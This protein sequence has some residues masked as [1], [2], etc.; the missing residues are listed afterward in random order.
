MVVTYCTV[1]DVSDF[2]RVPI[3]ATTTPNKT[4]VEKIINRKEDE[5]E[6]RIGHAWRERTITNEVHDLPLVYSFGWGTPVFLQHRMIKDMDSAQGDK[7]EIW[8]GS[9]D[10]YSDILGNTSWHNIEGV[11][12]K[13]FLRGF[14]FSILR[15]HRV[16]VTYRYGDTVVPGDITDAL[17]KMTAIELLNT[18][19]RM[20][21]L[22]MGGD[23]INMQNSMQKWQ[24]DIDRTIS[25]RR[26]V[27]VVR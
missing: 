21:K 22:P 1:T 13:L 16:R 20:D 7:I 11:Y 25:D 19:F 24:E 10:T 2:L 23:G 12:G 9:Q 15:K 3:T 26:E 4:Q 27:F 18:S 5:L 8:Q 14:I 6:R 17:I